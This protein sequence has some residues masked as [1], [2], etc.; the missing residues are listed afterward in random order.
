MRR[1]RVS[2]SLIVLL[3]LALAACGGGE[4]ESPG[5]ATPGAVPASPAAQVTAPPASERTLPPT[6]T[7]PPTLT[8]LADR[9]TLEITLDRSTATSF[10]LPTR[11][12][13]AAST[14]APS[15]VVPAEPAPIELTLSE[16]AI[17]EALVNAMAPAVG[18]YFGEGLRVTLGAGWLRV[19]VPLWT[20][21]GDSSTQ[22]MVA[23]E[24]E[25][26]VNDGRVQVTLW[27]VYAEDTGADYFTDLSDDVVAEVQD[28]IDRL[29]VAQVGPDV[30]FAVVDV[31]VS[32][33][34]ITFLI[35]RLDAAPTL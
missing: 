34:E 6:W 29:L 17:N 8:P 7:P 4:D 32:A 10:T 21:P 12:P 18:A 3:V 22:R 31:V 9:P 15:A 24:T 1:C 13:T 30:P 25:I 33:G 11:T 19:E 14:G 27:R 35:Q 23:V 5:S 20:T 28:Q 26:G 16:A 2:W